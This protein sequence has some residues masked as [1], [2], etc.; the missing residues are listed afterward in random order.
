M[1]KILISSLLLLGCTEKHIKFYRANLE[2]GTASL[3]TIAKKA[4]LQRSTAYIVA[5]ELLAMGLVEEDH[6]PY[7]KMFAAA[8]PERIL[9]KLEAK[10]RQLGRSSLAFRDAL[11]E[12]RAAHRSTTIRPRVRTF[13]GSA[14]LDAV[15]RDIL[16]EKQEILLWTNQEAERQVFG[17]STHSLFIKER[18][19]RQIPIR[20]LAVRNA[21]GEQLLPH[22]SQMLRQTKLLPSNVSF[23][24]ETYIYGNKTAVLDIG[25]DIFA[26]ITENSQ[27]AASQRAQFELAWQLI[28]E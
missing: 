22:D 24:S 18:L 17:R 4:R 5:A 8:E 20:V 1:D 25:K 16:A 3:I 2:L 7:K 19:E 10:Q 27:I 13:E 12:L 28:G 26:V 6:K 14:D 9:R 11:P 21:P 15:W 23:T